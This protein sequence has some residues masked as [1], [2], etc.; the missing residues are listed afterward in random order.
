MPGLFYLRCKVE[1]L[2][3]KGRSKKEKQTFSKLAIAISHFNAF[4]KIQNPLSPVMLKSASASPV[5]KRKNRR[6]HYGPY[7]DKTSIFPFNYKLKTTNY[8]LISSITFSIRS[9]IVS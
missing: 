3:S 9:F 6:F 8:K 7:S 2:I 1:Y 5:V 4:Y